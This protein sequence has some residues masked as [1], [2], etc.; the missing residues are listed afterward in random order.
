MRSEGSP[1]RMPTSIAMTPAKRNT[2]MMFSLRQPQ[3][4]IV[5]GI[6]AHRHEAAGAERELAAIAGE[7]VE[8]DRCD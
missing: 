7:D 4:Q 1:N 6:G 2:R 8:P 5:G 3:R